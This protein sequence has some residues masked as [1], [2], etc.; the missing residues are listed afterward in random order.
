MRTLLLCLALVAGSAICCAWHK[1]E[2][3]SPP[4]SAPSD[5]AAPEVRLLYPVSRSPLPTLIGDSTDIYVGA[6]DLGSDA[7][8]AGVA[9]VEFR[10][11]RTG[12]TEPTL[13]GEAVSSITLD[14]VA[15]PDIRSHL[16]L[17]AGWRLFTKRW[18]LLPWLQHWTGD[19]L[20]T[21]TRARLF[22]MAVD[23]AGNTGSAADSLS[24]LV[25]NTNDTTPLNNYVFTVQPVQGRVGDEF[26]F[27]PSP[28]YDLIDSNRDIRVRWDFDGET[29]SSWD[30]DWTDDYRADEVVRHTFS[31]PGPH[32]IVMEAH[33]SYLPDSVGQCRRTIRVEP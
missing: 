10:Y 16:G 23:S 27:D 12:E 22:A 24:V 14:Q 3:T 15:D 33:N 29:A 25:I 2:S 7:A 26:V 30:I 11:V 4:P 21:G 6:R 17:P 13:I 32:T 28:S 19:S 9:K 1:E 31:W 18:Y 20:T 5:Q 8:P